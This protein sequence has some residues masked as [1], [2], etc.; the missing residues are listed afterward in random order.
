MKKSILTRLLVLLSVLAL[1]LGMSVLSIAAA[2]DA[3]AA[4]VEST[5]GEAEGQNKNP[6][7]EELGGFFS[8][9]RIEYALVVTVQGMLMIFAVLTILWGVVAVLKLF[10][11][12]IPARREK[13]KQALSNAVQEAIAPAQQAEPEIVAASEEDEGE[14][15]AAITAAI[16][17]VLAS[18][19]YKD[20]FAS[21]FRVVSFKRKGGAWNREQ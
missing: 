5:V 21:G 15:V 4:E 12:D 2:D 7:N 9:E 13:K 17:C 19:E 1:L 14:I 18:D 10:V 11:H 6:T 8:A 16:A 3:G 20:E